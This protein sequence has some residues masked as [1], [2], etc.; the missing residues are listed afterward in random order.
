MTR[1]RL[2]FA[3]WRCFRLLRNI[4]LLPVSCLLILL[5]VV[6]RK[7]MRVRIM[8][9]NISRVGH[10]GIDVEYALSDLARR[11]P[12]ESTRLV[13]VPYRVD[14]P[15]AN[16][17]LKKMWCRST[18]SVPAT[19]GVPLLWAISRLGLDSQFLYLPPKRIANR[20]N[21]GSDPYGVTASGVA[22]LHFT[23]T[24]VEESTRCLGQMG[25]NLS[26][27]FVCL[28]V[29]DDHYH[30]RHSG[31]LWEEPHHWRNLSV[32]SFEQAAGLLAAKG[33]QVVRMGVHT[34]D[35]FGVADEREIF[36]YAN[37]GFRDELL[38]I[39]LVSRCSFMISTSSGIDS[40]SQ[41]FR[42]P[43]YNVGVV[44][45]SQLY[46][47]RN[48][49]SVVQRFQSVCDDRVLTLSET[50]KLPKISDKS[51]SEMGIKPIVNSEEEI[52][53]LADEAV[54]RHF[55]KWSPTERQLELQRRFIALLPPE[56]RRFQIRGGI[57]SHFLGTHPEWLM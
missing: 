28:H 24:E 32:R 15:V 14:L 31:G 6:T 18:T 16:R 46:I 12:R 7:L 49:F 48:I 3:V 19:I 17:T 13:I 38:D 8:P 52:V 37:N 33:F 47:H 4:T 57:G 43:L 27:P 30:T 9:M 11:A 54:K 29:R 26:R 35:S 21:W 1:S 50:L 5:L 53:Q 51:M 55:G 42:K 10:L 56:F 45:P 25:L 23:R 36:D 20:F 40:L 22:H 44:A 34:A 2:S 41:T 39:F